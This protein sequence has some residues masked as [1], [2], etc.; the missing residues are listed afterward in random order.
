MR[1]LLAAGSD[2]VGYLLKERVSDIAELAANVERV[3]RGETVIK[4]ILGT[5]RLPQSP[6]THGRGLAVL[7]YVHSP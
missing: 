1:A 7:A 4:S 5:L 3:A 2:G 6:D